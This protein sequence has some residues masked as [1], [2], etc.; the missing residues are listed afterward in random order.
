MDLPHAKRANLPGIIAED[1]AAALR[2]L[3]ADLPD[4]FNCKNPH[5]ILICCLGEVP[6]DTKTTRIV[7][8][9]L[10]RGPAGMMTAE[11]AL[12]AATVAVHEC[13]KHAEPGPVR[14]LLHGLA[15]ELSAISAPEGEG[16]AA[17]AAAA[18]R[19]Q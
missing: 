6:A 13:G 9:L 14:Q 7:G 3:S 11:D 1:L 18:E 15:R 10:T 17:G 5:S 2:Q 12:V 19:P 16:E 4:G 8:G